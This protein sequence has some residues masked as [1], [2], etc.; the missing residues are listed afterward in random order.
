MSLN[1]HFFMLIS[2]I[3]LKLTRSPCTPAKEEKLFS[4]VKISE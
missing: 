4:L 1:Q 2:F 3:G